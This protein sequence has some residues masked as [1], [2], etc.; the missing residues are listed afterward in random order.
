MAAARY[1][2]FTKSAFG[3]FFCAFK[4]IA[5]QITPKMDTTAQSFLTITFYRTLSQRFPK[6]K[7]RTKVYGKRDAE[8]N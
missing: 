3:I 7:N 6:L 1:D 8:K 5:R 4:S 2:P